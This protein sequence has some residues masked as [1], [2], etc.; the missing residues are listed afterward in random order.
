MP[1]KNS[2]LLSKDEKPV[3]S[4]VSPAGC[5]VQESINSRV[6]LVFQDVFEGASPRTSNESVELVTCI[7]MLIA[8]F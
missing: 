2:L 4:V 7:H 6:A 8:A 3:E 1:P 5:R